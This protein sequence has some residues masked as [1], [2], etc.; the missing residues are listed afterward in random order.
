MEKQ[1]RI[2]NLL[3]KGEPLFSQMFIFQFLK[4]DIVLSPK[5]W[6]FYD[7]SV[8]F[9]SFDIMLCWLCYGYIWLIPHINPLRSSPIQNSH[10]FLPFSNFSFRKL[11]ILIIF[12]LKR[13]KEIDAFLKEIQ[14]QVIF[15]YFHILQL[16][17]LSINDKYRYWAVLLCALML[18]LIYAWMN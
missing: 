6:W 11:K 9:S 13:L 18:N 16:T 7:T 1:L 2:T 4:M 17:C 12:G 14:N 15:C 8:I 3:I 10:K 5:N